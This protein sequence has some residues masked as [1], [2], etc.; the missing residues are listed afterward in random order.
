MFL[1]DGYSGRSV[2]SIMVLVNYSHLSPTT[3]KLKCIMKNKRFTEMS[4]EAINYKY[5]KKCKSHNSVLLQ[6]CSHSSEDSYSGL[7]DY[8]HDVYF[9]KYHFTLLGCKFGCFI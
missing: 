7:L 1:L 4:N 2:Y 3:G 5:F 8:K 9:M 6:S